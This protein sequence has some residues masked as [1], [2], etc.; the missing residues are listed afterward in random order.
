MKAFIISILLI[1]TIISHLKVDAQ[2]FRLFTSDKLSSNLITSI[3]QDQTG[4][5][6]IGTE[7]GLNKFDGYRFTTYLH[8]DGDSTTIHDNFITNIYKDR[9]GRLIIGS[10]QGI[11]IYDYKKDCFH[12]VK[13]TGNQP[14]ISSFSQFP[15]GRLLACT[16]GYGAFTIDLSSMTMKQYGEYAPNSSKNFISRIY[17]DN[18]KNLWM[19]G[20][21][22]SIS[23]YNGLFIKPRAAHIYPSEF[24]IPQDFIIDKR[25]KMLILCQHGLMIYDKEKDCMKKFNLHSYPL[26][27][28]NILMKSATINSNGDIYIGTADNG[29]FC[30]KKGTNVLAPVGTNI[31]GFNLSASNVRA[32]CED[33]EHNFWIDC[34]KKGLLFIPKKK[35]K[36]STWSFAEQNYNIGG[37]ISS[38]SKGD[39]GGIW[40]TIQNNGIYGF[41]KI[42]RI[43]KHPSSPPHTNII[44]KDKLGNYWIG[45][46]NGLFRYNPYTGSSKLV[47]K[48][49]GETINA[50]ED[51]GRGTLFISDFGKG[52]KIFNTITRRCRS[53]NMYMNSK[54][55]RLNNDWIMT[56]KYDSQGVLW[57]GNSAGF[58]QF[59]PASGDFKPRNGHSYLLLYTCNSFFELPDGNMLIGTNAG[60]FKFEKKKNT[61]VLFHGAKIL[62]NKVISS[63]VR[64]KKGDLWISTSMGIWQYKT[65]KRQFSAYING[66][67]LTTHEYVINAVLHSD[68]DKIFYGTSDGITTF[69]PQSVKN[70]R[71]LKH[72]PILTN[73][74]IGGK[75]VNCNTTSNGDRITETEVDKSNHFK[76]SY[77]DNTFSMEFSMMEYGYAGNTVYEYRLNGQGEWAA[78]EEGKNAIMFN[79]LQSG[80]YAVEVRAY[81]NGFYSPIKTFYVIITPPWY[82][83]AT[84]YIL[85][86]FILLSIAGYGL[87]VYNR[88]RRAELYE[89]NMKFLINA[90]HDIRS[91]L[92]LI[93]G[94]LHKLIEK[95]FDE[96]TTNELNMIDR[97]A[98]RILRLVNQILDARK[99]DKKLMN[100]HCQQ[101]N[102]VTYIEGIKNNFAFHAIESRIKF[103]FEHES[104]EIDAWIDRIN[105]DKVISN[106]LSN[107]F[108]FTFDGGE[109]KITLSCGHD[110]QASKIL[111]NYI[112]IK[113]IDSGIGINENM[114]DKVFERFYQSSNATSTNV[115][116]TGIGLNVC[117]MIV[118]LHHGTIKAEN[119]N[120]GHGTC[121]TIRI[122]QGYQH[123]TDNE[124]M[125][126][127]DTTIITD[128]KKKWNNARYKILIV[129][130]DIDIC[131]YISEELSGYFKFH[132]CR[133][134]KEALNELLKNSYDLVI[135]DVMM[136]EM[137]G[138]TLTRIIKSNSLIS[139]I[140]IILLT[141]KS[142]IDNRLTGF[143]KGADAY[144]GKPFDMEELHVVINNLIKNMLRLKGKFSGAQH[145][146][147]KMDNINE[148]IVGN[149][150]LLMQRIM[151]SINK[152]L[153]NSEFNVDMLA[154]DVGLSRAQLHRKMKDMTGIATGE[155]IRNLRLDQAAKLLKDNKV[156]ITQVA[157]SVGFNNQTHFSTVF[158]KHFGMS[159]SEYV[160]RNNEQ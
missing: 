13:K 86:V 6:W 101:T 7:Y 98:K 133:N 138:F 39:N 50:I 61:A 113:V 36:F 128:K 55:G 159:P 63:I 102:L 66:N 8:N 70:S 126:D 154:N 119:R 85:Y 141:S 56:L 53:Y 26:D 16:A 80:S 82:S 72:M 34:K 35:A 135:S 83:S 78:T 79:H 22:P 31:K 123:L 94:P 58:I 43:F 49:E 42:G 40:C 122:P 60:L 75:F 156:N 47:M 117:K 25:G 44:Y 32:I 129:D 52:L 139:H 146:E 111:K 76:I 155:F 134:G 136:P 140:P 116:G 103:T 11:S 149:D 152:N 125:H 38:I 96:E 160:E 59:S 91:P 88:H 92:T 15:D 14:H 99:L 18:Q 84:A 144:I 17:I 12:I 3:C 64:D 106:I 124:L 97:N 145:Q 68:D 112:E 147:G 157:Y 9:N 137:D 109:I 45:S 10:S 89:S 23:K 153:S 46:G 33:R 108:K 65:D 107:A 158:R 4:Y 54:N 21:S 71:A 67:G 120:D 19:I 77:L 29:I 30:I 142:D 28:N 143:E 1:L 151:K 132:T 20:N 148:E 130:D 81:I 69:Y 73:L 121:M 62:H 100:L 48:I 87:Y 131:N 51:D 110:N 127:E 37:S 104:D 115:Q 5:I 41:D 118:D 2:T 95:K 105:F 90:T 93:M 114:M 74:I 150:E 24:G 27:I 57:I